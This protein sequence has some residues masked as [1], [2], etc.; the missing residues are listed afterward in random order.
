MQSESD[1][2]YRADNE[3]SAVTEKEALQHC[4]CGSWFRYDT[5]YYE[6]A[7]TTTRVP[8]ILGTVKR[9]NEM[10]VRNREVVHRL[11]IRKTPFVWWS[12]E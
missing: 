5:L 7:L 3:I 1:K 8:V 11:G 12:Q 4:S 6:S 10:M 2:E 9:A